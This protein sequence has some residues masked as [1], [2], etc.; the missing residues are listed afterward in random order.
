MAM[1]PL[2]GGTTMSRLPPRPLQPRQA[3]RAPR[4]LTI[5]VAHP[6][7][8]RHANKQRKPRPIQ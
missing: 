5:D 1:D 4:R 6:H 8:L 3:L 7:R 2:T